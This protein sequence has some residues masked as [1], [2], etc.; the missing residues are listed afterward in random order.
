MATTDKEQTRPQTKDKQVRCPACSALAPLHHAMLD[1]R[2]GKA[3]L[4][5]LCQCGKSIWDE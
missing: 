1:T 4:I 5:Y 3:V 2:N